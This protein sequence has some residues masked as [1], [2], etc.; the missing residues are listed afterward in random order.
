MNAQTITNAK[1]QGPP[2]GPQSSSAWLT[3]TGLGVAATLVTVF[4]SFVGYGYALAVESM[5]GVPES[6][7]ADSPLDYLRLSSNVVGQWLSASVEHLFSPGIY[8][9]MLAAIWPV[10]AVLSVLWILFLLM[11]RSTR[12]QCGV[13][14]G[15]TK[16]LGSPWVEKLRRMAGRCMKL[17]KWPLLGL[18]GLWAFMPTA[19]AML[20]LSV[21]MISLM[22]A[23]VPLIGL[24]TGEYHLQKW[25]IEPTVCLPTR[26]QAVRTATTQQTR[27]NSVP[28]TDTSKKKIRGVACVRVQ[29]E[30]KKNG[31]V[32]HQGR[33]VVTTAKW[34]VLFDPGSGAVW[35]LPVSATQVTVVDELPSTEAAP[36][37]PSSDGRSP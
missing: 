33:V 29:G 17:V 7:F 2:P 32:I 8:V 24:K 20:F 10:C 11:R 34:I 3:P 9:Q 28:R 35:R 23:A 30:D 25:V 21:V 19:L 37:I 36:V 18:A 27:D 6:L 31:D 15:Q 14:A 4:L 26:S 12:Q 1:E 16:V 5:F 13:I 22:M